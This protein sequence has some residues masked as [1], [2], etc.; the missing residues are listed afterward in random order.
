M[1]RKKV[2]QLVS[3]LVRISQAA[4]LAFSFIFLLVPY[5]GTLRK[6]LRVIGSGRS[7]TLSSS[8][9]SEN[10]FGRIDVLE[11]YK[12]SFTLEYMFLIF[13]FISLVIAAIGIIPKLKIFKKIYFA[14]PTLVSLI[15]LLWLVIDEN[16]NWHVQ[17]LSSMYGYIT[18]SEIMFKMWSGGTVPI[19]LILLTVLTLQIA[20]AFVLNKIFADKSKQTDE[21]PAEAVAPVAAPIA[22]VPAEK[23]VVEKVPNEPAPATEEPVAAAPTVDPVAAKVAAIAEE[24][25]RYKELVDEGII[26]EEDFEQK[27]K[28]IIERN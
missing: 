15:T 22:E 23:P 11:A 13:L 14:I 10:F 6:T 25:K 9:I 2:G 4:L 1:T 16:N 18:Q 20:D 27:K 5:S 17:F 3:M 8:Y 19:F 26:T 21:K 24:I 7:E 28:Q 12:S